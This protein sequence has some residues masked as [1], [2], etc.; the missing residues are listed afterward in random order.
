MDIFLRRLHAGAG[1]LAFLII[2]GFQAATII[3]EA[4]GDRPAIAAVKV[5]IAWL[6]LLLVPTLATTGASGARLAG[7]WRNPL[8]AA[9]LRRMKMAAAN[10]LLV[11]VP[12][13]L[14]LAS[15]ASSGR[16]DTT[17]AA[18]QAIEIVAGLIN[19][20]LLGANIR[21]GLQLHAR[22]TAVDG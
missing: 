19:L 4:S 20:W 18:V 22:R 21:A 3:A 13:A 17:F 5:S 1:S 9:K 16:F 7:H 6:L 11:L 8:I 10:G 12:C 15:R 14:F 2:A